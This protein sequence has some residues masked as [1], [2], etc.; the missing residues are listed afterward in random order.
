M[1][2][3]YTALRRK[4]QRGLVNMGDQ[5][6]APSGSVF[7]SFPAILSQDSSD[8]F[9]ADTEVLSEFP[10]V[11]RVKDSTIESGFCLLDDEVFQRKPLRTPSSIVSNARHDESPIQKR[12]GCGKENASSLFRPRVPPSGVCGYKNN[13]PDS[14]VTFL[15]RGITTR[16]LPHLL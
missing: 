10:D 8:C 5:P 9:P 3:S 16:S 6:L 2:V 11:L 12:N 7:A 1:H 14:F 13:R 15:M 4:Q